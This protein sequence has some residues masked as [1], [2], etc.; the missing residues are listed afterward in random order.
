MDSDVSKLLEEQ[1][2][3][4]AM[5]GRHNTHYIDRD[6]VEGWFLLFFLG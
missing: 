2:K 4:L 5:A 1:L 6:V 3:G